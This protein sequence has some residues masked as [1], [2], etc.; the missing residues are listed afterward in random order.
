MTVKAYGT[1]AGD[2][3]LEPMEI[4]RRATGA[5]DVQIDIAYCGICH[6]DLH[7]ARGEWAGTQYPCVPGHEI[8][9]RVAAVGAHVAGFKP[10]DLVGI[11]CIVDSCKHCEECEVGLENY[12]D[13][14]VGT[15]NFPTADEP[16]YTLGGFALGLGCGERNHMCPHRMG[17][18]D[19]H[20]A[21]AADTD[22]TH[23]LAGACLPVA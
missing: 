2:K 19:P 13:E 22:D 23:F 5:H 17:Q 18:L 16:G 15:Y 1:L 7:Q 8:V 11:G 3:L 6:S 14:M 20:V 12:C 21:Q 10:G 4:S 9:G